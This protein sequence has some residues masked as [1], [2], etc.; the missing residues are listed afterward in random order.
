MYD[1][2]KLHLTAVKRI[3]RYLRGTLD[4]GLLLRYSSTQEFIVYINNDETGYS[5]NPPLA[6]SCLLKTT[7]SPG[8]SSASQWSPFP[9]SRVSTAFVANVVTEVSCLQQ[10][11][12]EL[13]NPLTS[14]TLICR[15]NV[16]VVYLSI[17]LE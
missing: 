1:L 13:Y 14:S 7:S 12:Q 9:M 11:L 8:P 5:D 16:N 17:N 2:R 10:L 4:Y 15:N 3:L 6:T